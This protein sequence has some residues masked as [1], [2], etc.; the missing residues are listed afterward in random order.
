MKQRL[1]FLL[2]YV[3]FWLI[4]FEFSRLFFL[5]YNVSFT[6]NTPFVDILQSFTSGFRHDLSLLGYVSAIVAIVSVISLFATNFNVLFK[7]ER[8]I[9]TYRTSI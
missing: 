2:R 6:T 1:L 4:F 5:L 7:Y 8:V 3:L 9:L